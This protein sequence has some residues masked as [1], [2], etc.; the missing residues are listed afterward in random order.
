VNSFATIDDYIAAQ[1]AQAQPRLRELRDIIRQT[2][3]GAS[4]SISYGMPTFTVGGRRVHFA[5]AKRHCALYGAALDAFPD[6]LRAYKT[7]RGTVQFP[8]DQPVPRDLVRKL[9]AARFGASGDD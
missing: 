6:E 4:E 2:I 8:L 9:V 5:A 7:L 3:P 1:S